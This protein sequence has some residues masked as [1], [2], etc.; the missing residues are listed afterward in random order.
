MQ[1]FLITNR[2]TLSGS[3]GYQKSSIFWF[4]HLIIHLEVLPNIFLISTN[5]QVWL[6]QTPNPWYT[7]CRAKMQ[8]NYETA[9]INGM[10]A[11]WCE[12]ETI[13]RFS[14]Y[15]PS[16]IWSDPNDHSGFNGQSLLVSVSS[17]LLPDSTCTPS[18]SDVIRWPQNGLTD[19]INFCLSL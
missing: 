10:F 3:L 2:G 6:V 8:F 5:H 14:V 12:S 13:L 4:F 19:L 7:R 17:R 1:W 15:W 16:E 11:T 9:R 18:M